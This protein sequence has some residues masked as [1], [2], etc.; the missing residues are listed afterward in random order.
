MYSEIFSCLTFC[1]EMSL[2]PTFAE[3]MCFPLSRRWLSLVQISNFLEHPPA[4]ELHFNELNDNLM[5]F[6]PGFMIPL[7]QARQGSIHFAFRWELLLFADEHPIKPLLLIWDQILLHQINLK[8][9]LSAL[10]LAHV[11]QIPPLLPNEIVV[12]KLQTFRD[13]DVRRILTD[14]EFIVKN[15]VIQPFWQTGQFRVMILA[16][17]LLMAFFW[18]H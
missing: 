15:Q 4:T 14:A 18:K 5:L 10:C 8:Q 12:E 3:S 11:H 9:Y 7:R 16:G 1:S 13:W 17:L 6:A 2:P